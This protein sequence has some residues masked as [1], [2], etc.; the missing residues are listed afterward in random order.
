MARS[1]NLGKLYDELRTLGE[2]AVRSP[3]A[4]ADHRELKQLA[5]QYGSAE[6]TWMLCVVNDDAKQAHL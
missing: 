6:V 3:D 2:N 5:G 4:G 1:R